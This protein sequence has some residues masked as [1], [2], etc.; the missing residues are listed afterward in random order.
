MPWSTLRRRRVETAECAEIQLIGPIWLSSGYREEDNYLPQSEQEP[1]HIDE[2][3]WL[4]A[5]PIFEHIKNNLINDSI[6]MSFLGNGMNLLVMGSAK[7]FILGCTV[8]AV[9]D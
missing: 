4:E 1:A 2:T 8:P 6:L 7:A 9:I 5:P 3:H